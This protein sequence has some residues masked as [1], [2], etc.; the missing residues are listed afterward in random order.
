MSPTPGVKQPEEPPESID[1][2]E[3]VDY[4]E[5]LEDY[6]RFKK[7]QGRGFSYRA[8]SRRAGLKSPNHLKR[9]TDGERNLTQDMARRYARALGLDGSAAEYFVELVNF[10]QVKGPTH[11]AAAYQKLLKFRGYQRAHRLD[12][13]HAAYHSNW[14]LPAIRELIGCPGFRNDPEWIAAQLVPA[15]NPKEAERAVLTLLQLGLVVE[16]A[17][18]LEQA[19]PVLTTGAETQGVHIVN[20]HRGMLE[21]AAESIDLVSRE[22]RDISALT[23][24]V[25]KNGLARIKERVQAFRKEL[26]AI[27]VEE[28]PVEQVVQLNMQLFPLSKPPK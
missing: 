28:E 23:F 8:F 10:N 26:L 16:K 7:A 5:F 2:F 6:Y 20:Y 27:A 21:R 19:E 9:V 1:V 18:K 12:V 3:Y 25:G 14:Y 13:A 17:G 22:E 4:R 24:A 11:R 15:I